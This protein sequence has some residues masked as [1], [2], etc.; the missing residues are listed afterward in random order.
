L[1]AEIKLFRQHLC[2]DNWLGRSD[3]RGLFVSRRLSDR[4]MVGHSKNLNC[5]N[6]TQKQWSKFVGGV[7]ATKQRR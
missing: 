5:A 2:S 3:Q 1:A 6:L 4:M 7:N